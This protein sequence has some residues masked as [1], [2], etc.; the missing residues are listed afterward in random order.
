[1][2]GVISL[3]ANRGAALK[4][5]RLHEDTDCDCIAGRSAE[6]T[7][8]TFVRELMTADL[9]EGC[10]STYWE[11]NKRP[12]NLSKCD[13]PNGVCAYKG[14][15]VYVYTTDDDILER[16]RDTY[17]N[18]PK[19]RPKRGH[20]CIVRFNAG[21]GRVETVALG[22]LDL[23]RLFFKS[24]K[25]SILEHVIPVRFGDYSSVPPPGE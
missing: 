17:R 6:N 2:L 21:G 3:T 5:E 23:H 10:F 18:A 25:F 11:E 14:A 16:R 9:G 7:S 20:W 4:F 8:D 19:A 22:V 24:D 15:S 1:V 12:R 13:G